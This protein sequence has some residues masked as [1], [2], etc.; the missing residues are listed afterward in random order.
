MSEQIDFGKL[1]DNDFEVLPQ[2]RY[3][4]ECIE[5]EMGTS[6]AGNK[7]IKT[8]FKVSG[9][10]YNNRR[11]WNDFSLVPKAQF[12]LKAYFEA[13]DLN[14]S[15]PIEVDDIPKMLL[16]S[17]ASV[18]VKAGEFNGKPTTNLEGWGAFDSGEDKSY[19][20]S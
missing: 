7:K 4:V 9:G 18:F 11:L 19:F 6:K 5:A 17:K 14:T 8:Q 3:N 13:A 16:G 10:D 20:D 15:G 12:V 1:P 2:D